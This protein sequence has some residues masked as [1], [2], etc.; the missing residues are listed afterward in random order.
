M[1]PQKKTYLSHEEYLS[2]ERASESRNEYLNGDIFAM[3][4]ASRNHNQISSNIVRLLGNQLLDKPCSV[5]AGD[6]KI[7]IGKA[8]KYT[9]PDIAVSCDTEEFEDENEDVLLNPLVIIEILSDSTEAYDRGLKFFHY[10]F[11]DSLKEYIL[12]SQKLCRAEKF[13]RQN[14]IWIYSE[15]HSMDNILEIRTINCILPMAEV[16]RK[17]RWR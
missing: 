17:V 9:Y 7:K 4:G 15:I 10:Q 3:A 1:I 13:E 14:N 12:I 11:T 16:Y 2:Y 5:Y 6:M 8:D